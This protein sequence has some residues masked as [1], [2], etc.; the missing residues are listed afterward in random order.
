MEINTVVRKTR[1]LYEFNN[2]I[3]CRRFAN[4]LEQKF[5][6][7]DRLS[8]KEIDREMKNFFNEGYSSNSGIESDWRDYINDIDSDKISVKIWSNKYA[9][10]AIKTDDAKKSLTVEDFQNDIR[11]FLAEMWEKYKVTPVLR[12]LENSVV[13]FKISY[14]SFG[15]ERIYKEV[16]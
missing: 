15:K 12:E 9:T 13:M 1:N 16:K 6:S 14:D 11:K 10:M 5:R 2:D 4:K 3:A 8:L 7:G